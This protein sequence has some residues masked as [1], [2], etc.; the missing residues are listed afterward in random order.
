MP[1]TL[2]TM[3]R[4]K[5]LIQFV[6]E[7]ERIRRIDTWR[8]AHEFPTRAAAIKWLLEFALDQ[9]PDPEP[10]AETEATT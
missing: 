2:A 7:K 1:A 8:Y 4:E 9:N 3:P 6:M 5:P 10:A